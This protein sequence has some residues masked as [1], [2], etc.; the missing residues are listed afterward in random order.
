MDQQLKYRDHE[1]QDVLSEAKLDRWFWRVWFLLVGVSVIS[2]AALA[3][4]IETIHSSARDPWP[5]EGTDLALVGALFLLMVI[6]AAYMTHQQRRIIN[7]K[8]SLRDAERKSREISRRHRNHLVAFYSVSAVV[9]QQNDPQ[10]VFDYIV[11]L[12]RKVFEADRVS[13]MILDFKTQMLEVRAA[14]GHENPE[15]VIGSKRKLG[16]GISGWVAQQGEPLLLGGAISEQEYPG[17]R[18]CD[19][20]I[21]SAMVVPLVVRNEVCGV[22]NVSNDHSGTIYDREDLDA[23][24]VFSEIAE[25]SIRHDEQTTWMRQTIETLRRQKTPCSKGTESPV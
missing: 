25:Y 3:L 8:N 24:R 14:I 20:S 2:I 15:K 11:R 22:L 1:Q 13:L 6:F 18:P 16:E 23:L 17:H 4:T 19:E 21:V 12:C 7:L 10:K 9:G 5:W